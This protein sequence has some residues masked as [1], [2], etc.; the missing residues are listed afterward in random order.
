MKNRSKQVALNSLLGVICS[1]ASLV[2]AYI[3]RVYINRIF[4]DEIY[5]I[6]SLFY[7]IVNTMLIFELGISSA[8]VIFLFKPIEER[9]N[10]KV[11]SIIALYKKIYC[12][13][14]FS[15]IG[16]GCLFAFVALDKIINTEVDIWFVRFSFILY[17][18]GVSVK[19]LWGY[20]KCLLFASQKNRIA[21]VINASVDAVFCVLSIIV[22]VVTKNFMLYLLIFIMQNIVSNAV[23]NGYVNK[24]Y[25]FIREK[26]VKNVDSKFKVEMVAIIRP[27]F[28]QRISN[29]IS[30]TSSSIILGV[31][32]NVSLVGYYSNYMII[33]H[34]AQ[35]ILSQIGSSFTTSFG[36]YITM[37]TDR[38][39]WFMVYKTFRTYV[40]VFAILLS[41]G[42]F[43]T[44]DYLVVL[45]FGD[46]SVLS[47]GH[48]LLIT[49]YLYITLMSTVDIAVQNAAG[50]HR[51]DSTMVVMQTILTI[52]FSVI[53]GHFWGL[54]GIL[55]GNI[56]PYFIFTTYYKPYYIFSKYFREKSIILARILMKELCLLSVCL[57]VMIFIKELL[58]KKAQLGIVLTMFVMG[59]ISIMIW[60]CAVFVFEL[61]G[62]KGYALKEQFISRIKK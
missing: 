7:S 58:L 9:D 55:V 13:F 6:N 61:R 40:S 43:A 36:N 56:V 2:T 16:V 10:E 14:S 53:G 3:V 50:I 35:T 42:F 51:L 11:K 47:F 21:S 59:S 24:L 18:I 41:V 54:L 5:G 33:V 8:I 46:A 12:V 28:V 52:V 31:F 38:K 34:A 17:V 4:G 26:R 37:T 32:D 45:L 15:L 30:N 22:M 39:K 20:K 27:L 49:V 1:F 25:P 23:C 19:Y 57:L 60:F 62:E 44:V 29:Q 48:L